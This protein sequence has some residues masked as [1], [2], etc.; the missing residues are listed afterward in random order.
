MQEAHMTSC[1]L[2]E[3]L[4]LIYFIYFNIILYFICWKWFNMIITT[5]AYKS[6]IMLFS[7]TKKSHYIK[8]I[9]KQ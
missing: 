8:I 1:E 2:F 5:F 3:I 9:S 4:D 7:I 6:L